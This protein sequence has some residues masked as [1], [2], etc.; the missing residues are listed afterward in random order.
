MKAEMFVKKYDG[1]VLQD[2]VTCNSQEF[3]TFANDFRSVAKE[4]AKR[5]GADLVSFSVGHYFFSVFMSRDGKFVYFSY[6]L[7]RH[8]TLDLSRSDSWQGI[9]VRTA[10][11]PKDYTGGSNRFCNVMQMERLVDQL[12]R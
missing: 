2:A 6:D 12:L 10:K 4:V 11:H 3:T 8:M 5:I 1:K 9:L 7:P